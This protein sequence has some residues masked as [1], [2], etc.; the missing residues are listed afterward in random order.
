MQL[1]D[2][3]QFRGMEF[4]LPKNAKYHFVKHFASS[5]FLF[6]HSNGGVTDFSFEIRH[7]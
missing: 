7:G 3:W 2:N 4:Q 5:E 6:C 1:S